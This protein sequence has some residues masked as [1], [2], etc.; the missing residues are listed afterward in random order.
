MLP[1]HRQKCEQVHVTV[2]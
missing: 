1:D 2:I